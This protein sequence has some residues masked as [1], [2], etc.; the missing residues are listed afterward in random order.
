MTNTHSGNAVRHLEMIQDVIRRMASDSFAI[1]RWSISTTA[2]LVGAAIATGEPAIAFVAWVSILTYWVLDTYY[3]REERW[4][5]TL[6][7]KVRREPADVEPFSMETLWP[8]TTGASFKAT[9]VS[10][11]ELLSHAPLLIVSAA[12]GLFLMLCE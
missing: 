10:R 12:V 5:R 8:P 11:T 9:L 7:D 1:R 4:L 2:A 3:L 6:Y